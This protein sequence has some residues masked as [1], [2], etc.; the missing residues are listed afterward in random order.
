MVDDDVIVSAD[1]HGQNG[2]NGIV[3]SAAPSQATSS[4]SG[5]V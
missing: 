1:T 3:V 2:Q 5:C 4:S